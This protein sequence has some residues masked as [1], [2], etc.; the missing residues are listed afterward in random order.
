VIGQDYLIQGCDDMDFDTLDLNTDYTFS[1]L[2]P[3]ANPGGPG[4]TR[5]RIKVPSTAKR[6][7]LRLSTLP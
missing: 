2:D 1:S 5:V 3:V 6:Y 7:F 4:M